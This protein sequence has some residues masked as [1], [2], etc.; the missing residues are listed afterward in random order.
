[1]A[2]YPHQGVTTTWVVL[3]IAAFVL[4][5]I[6]ISIY[7]F[8][9]HSVKSHPDQPQSSYVYPVSQELGSWS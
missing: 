1:M 8:R 4:V 7:L 3:G 5:M 9:T 2:R 6:F